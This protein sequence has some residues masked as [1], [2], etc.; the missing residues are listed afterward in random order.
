MAIGERVDVT[1]IDGGV[2]EENREV[3]TYRAAAPLEPVHTTTHAGVDF[4]VRF[5]ANIQPIAIRVQDGPNHRTER[6]QE[7][8]VRKQLPDVRVRVDPG[9]TH[10]VRHGCRCAPPLAT[11]QLATDTRRP[12]RT[13][14][15]L[16][17]GCSDCLAHCCLYCSTV[18]Q[19]L[20]KPLHLRAHVTT[21][22]T[23]CGPRSTAPSAVPP[24]RP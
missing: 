16:D 10:V 22:S 15:V 3:T 12:T 8:L 23:P 19:D 21:P 1:V 11:R 6:G 4:H 14:C 9:F 7:R 20:G 5:L 18:I 17:V 2:S 24:P 13:C